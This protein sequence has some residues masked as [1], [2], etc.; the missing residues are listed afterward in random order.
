MQSKFEL[1]YE[2]K[3]LSTVIEPLSTNMK[4]AILLLE[5]FVVA[6]ILALIVTIASVS[7]GVQFL[8]TIVIIPII[9]L[10]IIFIYF[11]KKRK[12]WS[13]A[14]ASILGA[15]GVILRVLVNTKPNLE[16]GGGLPIGVTVVYIVIGALV[17]LKNYE[18]V[19]ELRKS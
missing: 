3:E 11:C 19:L 9:I 5:V 2:N 7:A 18:S 8:A 10:S 4:T 6:I 14:G 13:Y 1:E 12:I 15:V 16:V 17:S